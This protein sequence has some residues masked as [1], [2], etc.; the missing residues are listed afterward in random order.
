MSLYTTKAPRSVKLFGAEGVHQLRR[1]VV[2]SG[3]SWNEADVQRADRVSLPCKT[4]NCSNHPSPRP[5]HRTWR[6]SSSATPWRPASQEFA[7]DDHHGVLRSLD[8]F[9]GGVLARGD[10]SPSPRSPACSPAGCRRSGRRLDVAPPAMTAPK[11]DVENRRS[12]RGLVPM[13]T[14]RAFE[15]TVE[16]KRYY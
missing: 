5:S 14:S 10:L 1:N 13:S 2:R 9:A 6:E 4:L 3:R 8:S 12:V 11:F 16:L 7:T 15:P